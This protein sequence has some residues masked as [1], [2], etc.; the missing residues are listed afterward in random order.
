MNLAQSATKE[1]AIRNMSLLSKWRDTLRIQ[2]RA[3][4]LARLATMRLDAIFWRGLSAAI[5]GAGPDSPAVLLVKELGIKGS[6]E[7]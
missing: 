7:R 2:G 1:M 3:W 6:G 4:P 5:H